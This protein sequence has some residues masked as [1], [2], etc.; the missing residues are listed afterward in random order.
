VHELSIAS[1]LIQAVT[2]Q[3]QQ[4]GAERVTAINLVVGER[5]GIV[6]DSLR[7]CFEMLAPDTLAAGAALN[8]RQTPM[9]FHCGPCAADYTPAEAV[10][11]CPRCGQFGQMVDDGAGLLI[12]SLEVQP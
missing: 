10:F 11:T 7:F 9:R 8:L 6:E 2:D 5:A 1:Y 4:S 12:E 3:A